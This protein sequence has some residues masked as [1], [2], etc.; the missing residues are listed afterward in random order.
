[1]T[2]ETPDDATIADRHVA[3]LLPTLAA[4]RGES[5]RIAT[6]GGVLADRL[7]ADGRLLAAGN[8]GSAAEA[9]HLT[10]ELV[11]RFDGDR[12]PFSAIA[13]HCGH[14]RADRDQQ[15]LRLRRVLLPAGH[16]ARAARRR[17]RAA[18]DER[19]QREPRA[20]GGGGQGRAGDRVGD[21]RARVRTRWPTPPTTR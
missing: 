15:R 12:R 17:A 9:Q 5:E 14:L 16:R 19:H 18:L 1:M 3:A 6:W 11:G 13:L 8:G 20:R 4:L 10:A 2:D 7:L 21:D